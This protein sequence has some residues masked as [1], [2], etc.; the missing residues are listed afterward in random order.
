MGERVTFHWKDYAHGSKQRK[1]TLSATEFLRRFVQHILPR[2]FVRIRQYGFLAN[3]CRAANLTVAR[4]LLTTTSE[5]P[6]ACSNSAGD[7]PTW[8]CSAVR[9]HDRPVPTSPPAN[10]LRHASFSTPRRR[11]AS[12]ARR[13]ATARR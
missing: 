8:H 9:S 1:M 11:V 3:R 13:R 12:L 5:P 7:A 2:G 4:Q 6:E 10:W